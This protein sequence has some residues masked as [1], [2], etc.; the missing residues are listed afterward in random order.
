MID[1]SNSQWVNLF[2][3]IKD[4]LVNIFDR[5]RHVLDAELQQRACEYYAIATR[6]D[7]DELI[8]VVCEEMPIYPERESALLSRLHSKGASSQD[9]R[10]WVIG[11]KDENKEREAE[12]FK[13]FRKGSATLN[14]AE[15]TAAATA[16]APALAPSQPEPQRSLPTR[17][18][19]GTLD[20]M[21]GASSSGATEDIM[22]SLAGLD[23]TGTTPQEQPLLPT[24][25]QSPST[26][27]P[28]SSGLDSALFAQVNPA[29]SA[30]L[31][32]GPN[33]E[34]VSKT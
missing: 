17:E 4:Q 1:R 20:T 26:I 21:M 28:Q 19:T 29:A 31:T 34:K 24:P 23:L 11:G 10:T 16:S 30:P 15:V 13:N 25:V 5:Y 6:E 27:E 9:K 2:P 18:R 12:R 8:Q 22:S 3:E 33:I 7:N 14:G 32:L